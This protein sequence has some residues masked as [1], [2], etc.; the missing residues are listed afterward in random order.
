MGIILEYCGI[1]CP[2]EKPYIESFFAQ[3][4][5]EEV[6]RN[7]YQGYSDA[8]IGWLNYKAWY[9]NDRIHQGLA[10]KTIVDFQAITSAWASHL[11]A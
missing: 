2:N 1:N 8:V 7:E 6:Y 5:R 9:N 4:K 11:V 10:W 3:Y